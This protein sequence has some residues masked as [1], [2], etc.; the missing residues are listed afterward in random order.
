MQRLLINRLF[1]II[2]ITNNSSATKQGNTG[3]KSMSPDR[4]TLLA[5]TIQIIN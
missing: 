3:I 5:V 4:K 2:T 1:H